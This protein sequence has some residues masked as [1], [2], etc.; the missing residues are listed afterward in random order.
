MINFFKGIKRA[1]DFFSV[2]PDGLGSLTEQRLKDLE[3]KVYRLPKATRTI[4]LEYDVYQLKRTINSLQGNDKEQK[5]SQLV[6]PVEKVKASKQP[7][8]VKLKPVEETVKK[9]KS[10]LTQANVKRLFEYREGNL[11]WKIKPSHGVQIGDEAGTKTKSGKAR[12]VRYNNTYYS[13]GHVIFLMFHGYR[14]QLVSFIDRN[15]LNTRIENLRAASK[16]QVR[17]YAKKPQNNT[18][19][20]KGVSFNKKINKYSAQIN[21]LG[22]HY[23]LGF[24][25]T[26]KEAHKAYCKA[27]KKLHGEFAQVA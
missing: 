11:Y 1:A 5:P 13:Y 20:Y 9:V 25:D 21:K 10:T 15:P 16:S 19:G 3:I 8:A 14:P 17:C 7:K 18:C 4:D 24:F 2:N 12:V 23:N 6:L 26:P 22:K 27:A